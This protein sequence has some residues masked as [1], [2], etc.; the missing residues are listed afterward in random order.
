MQVYSSGNIELVI[1]SY[2]A[3]GLDKQGLGL[4]LG[5]SQT[6]WDVALGL[7]IQNIT[8]SAADTTTRSALGFDARGRGYIHWQEAVKLG[9]LAGLWGRLDDDGATVLQ[10]DFTERFEG[11]FNKWAALGPMDTSGVFG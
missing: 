11:V 4:K 8:S 6:S 10:D 7:Q 2:D 1:D 9:W 3:K 5:Y